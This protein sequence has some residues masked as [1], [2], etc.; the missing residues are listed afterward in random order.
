MIHSSKGDMSTV[1]P[2]EVML[3]VALFRKALCMS[4]IGLHPAPPTASI[5]SKYHTIVVSHAEK[6]G[7]LSNVKRFD[8]L[9]M[10]GMH[11]FTYFYSA[12]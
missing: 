1:Y 11:Y 3:K 8:S 6:K 10:V 5:P 9:L 12:I 4:T 7:F 2:V